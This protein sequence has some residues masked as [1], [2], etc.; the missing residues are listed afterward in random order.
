MARQ[1]GTVLRSPVT[2]AGHRG[3]LQQHEKPG[4][5]FDEGA[6]RGAVEADDQVALPVAGNRSVLGLGRALADQ[7]LLGHEALPARSAAGSGNAQRP[8]GP[9][10]GREL[11]TQRS[12]PLDVQGLVDRLVRDPHRLIIGEIDLEPV[13]DLLRAPR[14]PPAAIR[15]A[16]VTPATPP[17]LG[18]GPQRSRPVARQRR[19][20]GPGRSAADPHWPRASRPSDASCSDPRATA[21]SWR[22]TPDRRRASRRCVAAR[23]RSSRENGRARARSRRPPHPRA[24]RIA[25]SSR[26]AND[27]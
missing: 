7:D 26:S 23:A 21:R 15:A 1:R 4:A 18:A 22:D 14:L 8:P 20:A 12:A 24:R 27:R 10:T 6:D 11:A 2:V 13:S 3:E 5:A 16:A 19:R 9:Q 25:I 17:H